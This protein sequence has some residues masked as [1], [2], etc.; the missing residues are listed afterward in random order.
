MAPQTAPGENPYFYAPEPPSPGARNLT[1]T[2]A[3]AAGWSPSPA[4]GQFIAPIHFDPSAHG[5]HRE[6][7]LPSLRLPIL[8]LPILRLFMGVEQAGRWGGWRVN[9]GTSVLFFCF[10]FYFVFRFSFVLSFYFWCFPFR[11]VCD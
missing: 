10:L 11:C 3:M 1:A 6:E 4:V 8:R 2:Q 7:N 9:L 5:Y